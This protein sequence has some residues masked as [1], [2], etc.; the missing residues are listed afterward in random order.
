MDREEF[1]RNRI[2]VIS[3]GVIE[4]IAP[5]ATTAA[6]VKIINE[7]FTELALKEGGDVVL[8]IGVMHTT[9]PNRESRHAS[10]N[11]V[12]VL[13][14]HAR[15]IGLYTEGNI[16]IS[17]ALKFIFLGINSEKYSIHLKRENALK[18]LINGK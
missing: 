8:L 4:M 2:N 17:T 18:S 6:D 7:R 9:L 14:K 13:L 1:I 16:F 15:K 11:S 5:P 3:P 10:K 12:P